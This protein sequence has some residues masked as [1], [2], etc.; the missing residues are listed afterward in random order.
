MNNMEI[1]NRIR[2]RRKELGLTQVQIHEATGIS[3]GNLSLI[4]NGKTLPSSSALVNLSNL[5]Q[6]SI[7]YLLK[8]GSLNLEISKLSNFKEIGDIS[9]IE[10]SL[11][12]LFR[13][14]DQGD[15]EEIIDVME[16]KI[17]RKDGR[18]KSL[19]SGDKNDIG[20]A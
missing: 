13:Q 12:K 5:L 14:L 2:Q 10:L 15:Q 19:N 9:D 18:R 11:I 1:G 4:E 17:K 20:I 7:D 3:S 8:G 6:C 16:L